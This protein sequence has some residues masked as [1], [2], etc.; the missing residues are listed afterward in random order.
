MAASASVEVQYGVCF[1]S[2]T[3]YPFENRRKKTPK[4]L[5][6]P[7]KRIPWEVT[8]TPFSASEGARYLDPISNLGPR[9]DGSIA[10]ISTLTPPPKK[11]ECGACLE[12]RF[13][14]RNYTKF[15]E[16]PVISSPQSS[17]ETR[18]MALD[19]PACNAVRQW[20][21]SQHCPCSQLVAGRRTLPPFLHTPPPMPARKRR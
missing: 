8:V 19:W 16:R 6:I 13:G 1:V 15:N 10:T 17:L 20:P 14:M 7:F 5:I 4:I 11:N 2:V 21:P 12:D 9:K 3:F 18:E